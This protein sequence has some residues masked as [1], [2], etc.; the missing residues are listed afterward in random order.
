MSNVN[1]NEKKK[2]KKKK[3][4]ITLKILK[5]N[6]KWFGDVIIVTFSQNLALLHL[7][8]SEKML[9]QADGR[10]RRTMDARNLALALLTQ[11]SRAKKKILHIRN[12]AI[13]HRT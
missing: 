1:E 11:S 6:K 13:R 7:M 4:G 10:L 2:K 3:K 8:V 5:N 9:L 12:K